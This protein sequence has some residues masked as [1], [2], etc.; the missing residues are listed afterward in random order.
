MVPPGEAASL[1]VDGT[2]SPRALVLASFGE[3]FVAILLF[4]LSPAFVFGAPACELPPAALPSATAA[5]LA[6]A[7][8]LRAKYISRSLSV[9]VW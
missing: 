3:G 7:T 1:L 8:R 9:S 5:L 6:S 2:R 4:M